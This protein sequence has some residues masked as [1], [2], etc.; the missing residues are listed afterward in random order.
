MRASLEGRFGGSSDDVWVSPLASLY[1][2][3][4]L[5]SVARS[6]LFLDR[7]KEAETIWD[8]TRSFAAAGKL[9]RE[10]AE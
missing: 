10:T 8:V 1:G 9:G 5:D 7:R 4:S 2:F 6:H 3:F